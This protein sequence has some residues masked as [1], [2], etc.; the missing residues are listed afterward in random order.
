MTLLVGLQLSQSSVLLRPS[1]PPSAAQAGGVRLVL[2][3]GITVP[4]MQLHASASNQE[5][6]GVES[7]IDQSQV[8]I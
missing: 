4:E 3:E 1:A 8:L 5:E 2:K 7:S 6:G